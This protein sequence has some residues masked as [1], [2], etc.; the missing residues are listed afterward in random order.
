MNQ[1]QTTQTQ[2]AKAA[3]LCQ[4]S[5]VTFSDLVVEVNGVHGGRDY[6]G[7]AVTCS[8]DPSHLVHELHGDPCRGGR[9]AG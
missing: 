5:S 3:P 1:K 9:A 2:V 8:H 4:W 6:V 7:L